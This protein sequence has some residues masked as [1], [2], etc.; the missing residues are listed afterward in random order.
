MSA[1]LKPAFDDAA[2]AFA[3]IYSTQY[4][5]KTVVIKMGGEVLDHADPTVLD[6]ILKQAVLLRLFGAKVV[7]V[8]GGGKQIDNALKAAGHSDSLKIDGIRVYSE[9]ELKIANEQA[10]MLSDRIITRLDEI[11]HAF[12]ADTGIRGKNMHHREI[13]NAHQMYEGKFTG[14]FN[15]DNVLHDRSS[16][17]AQKA[18]HKFVDTE[19][20][21][22]VLSND[23]NI[24]VVN[25][26]ANGLATNA[27][28]AAGVIAIAMG[29][30]RLMFFSTDKAGKI[31]GIHD[32][33]GQLIREVSPNGIDE[34]IAD[35]TI[36]G[37]MIPKAQICKYAIQAGVEGV[38]ILNPTIHNNIVNELLLSEEGSGTLIR[39]ADTNDMSREFK[40]MPVP[41]GMG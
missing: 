4:R 35:G 6:E 33:E 13:L 40:P 15:L 30:K 12:G 34:L 41:A 5:N 21:K 26:M 28:D 24:P 39:H 9:D 22:E 11:G 10:E 3:A 17:E 32:K 16:V 20:L 38:V 31:L 2:L 18:C 19:K 23:A 1:K 29:A 37:G 8:H 36:A 7:V 25:W 14:T 27:D